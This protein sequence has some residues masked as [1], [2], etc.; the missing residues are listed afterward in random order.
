M[1]IYKYKAQNAAKNSF[2]GL[3]E[4]PSKSIAIDILKEKGLE[5]L[6][7]GEQRKGIDIGMLISKVK[8]KDLVTFSR[9]FSVLI[10]ASV[11]I[12]QTL[13]LLADQT[14]SPKLKAIISEVSG[15]VEGG[16]R[17]SDALAK[18]PKVFNDFFINVIRSGENSGKLDEVLNYLADEVEKDYDMTSKIKGAMIYP[19]FV[20]SAM[21]G[22]G[23][24]MIVYVVPKLTAMIM[25][26]GTELPVATKILIWL[27]D[28]LGVYWPHLLV[29]AIGGV[30]GIKFLKKFPLFKVITDTA[31]LRLPIFGKLFRQIYVVRFARSLQTLLIGGVNL[32]KGLKISAD[33]VSNAVFKDIIMKTKKEVED[34]NSMSIIFAQNPIVPSMVAQMIS[35]GEKT[36]RLDTILG[37]IA[38]F[39]G[40]EVDNTIDNLMSLMEPMIMVMMGI[41]VAAMVMAIMMPMYNM[42]S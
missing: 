20:F 41:G 2:S 18:H 8:A 6:S 13:K 24:V 21:L 35:I 10:G 7:I 23:V 14:S 38:K 36:G 39:Y 37:S 26:S 28:V 4:A 3:V 9:Q 12:V 17:L 31:L 1:I 30:I 29:L 40:R 15:D 5:V 11:S 27:S 25:E 33:I 16:T 22:V 32:S 19:A 34:G 42:A